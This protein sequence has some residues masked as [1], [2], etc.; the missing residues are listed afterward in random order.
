MDKQEL[1]ELINKLLADNDYF[2]VDAN[3]GADQNITVYIDK[4]SGN[5]SLDDCEN[6]HRKLYPHLEQIYD[7]FE[8]TVSSPGL[9]SDLLVWQQ[10][11]KHKGQDIRIILKD[12][13]TIEGT[14]VDADQNQVKVQTKK[15]LLTIDYSQINKAKLIIKF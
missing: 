12:G 10:Y 4:Y 14:I 5:I 15:Q 3:I 7:N 1:I 13:R 6:L 2:V 11:Y 8:L 9:T